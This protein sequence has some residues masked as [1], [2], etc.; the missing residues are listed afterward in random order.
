MLLAASTLVTTLIAA[1]PVRLIVDTDAGFD[2]DDVGAI[3]VANALADNGECE[4]IAIGHTNGFVKGIGGVSTLM[5]FSGRDAP[6]TPLGSYKGPWAANPNA[7][8]GTSDHYLSDLTDHYPCNV[9]SSAQ[10][11]TAVDVYRAALAAS[12]YR[13]VRIASIGITTNMRDLLASPADAHSPLNGKD[14]VAEKVELVV[15]MI[16]LSTPHDVV[17][18]TLVPLSLSLS[19]SKYCLHKPS[20]FLSVFL[21]MCVCVTLSLSSLSPLSIFSISLSLALSLVSL[22]C[23]SLPSASLSPFLPLHLSSHIRYGWTACTTLAAPRPRRPTGL[24]QIQG[25]TAQRK[26]RL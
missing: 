12:P 16:L 6:T 4:I 7:G 18:A 23:L 3:G 20:L 15:R 8:K 17:H 2:V 19:L 10:T 9:T 26:P 21:F 14:L 25:A 22:L 13:S 24:A 5:R 1:T 11:P